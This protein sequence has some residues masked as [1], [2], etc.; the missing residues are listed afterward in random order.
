MRIAN[1]ANC[2]ALSEATDGAGAG[3]RTVF[4]VILGT[5]VGG[6]ITV[7]RTIVTGPNAIGGEWGHNP[8]PWPRADELPG[9]GCYCGLSGCIETWL[10]G[11]G[12]AG[13]FARVTGA[14]RDSRAIVKAARAGDEEAGAALDRYVDRLARGL[15]SII[16]VLDP[17]VIVLAGGM[18][19]IDELY[20]GVT[21]RWNEYVFSDRV[22]TPLLPAAH[23]DSS[24][25]RGAA[26]LWD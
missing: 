13:E 16:N 26:W 21:A 10:S 19:Q 18:S 22:D 15:S 12:M 24:G 5:G 23:G 2:F 20:D 7:N 14:S 11:P 4:A 8:L 3:Y 25:V 9:P 1:D 17:D 6:G